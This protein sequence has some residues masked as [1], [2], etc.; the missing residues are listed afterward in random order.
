MII[1]KRTKPASVKKGPVNGAR[2][3]SDFVDSD[4]YRNCI[5]RCNEKISRNQ[6]DE[7][8]YVER[9]DAQLYLDNPKEALNDYRRAVAINP[10]SIEAYYGLATVHTMMGLHK[11]ALCELTKAM[12]LAEQQLP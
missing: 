1:E 6:R 11:T 7:L 2:E 12:E 3:K 9:G 5:K 10:N 8:A 4:K